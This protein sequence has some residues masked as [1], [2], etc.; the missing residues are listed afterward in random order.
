MQLLLPALLSRA[1][2]S[3]DGKARVIHTA[4]LGSTFAK[5]LDYDTFND[6]L[7]F[8]AAQTGIHKVVQSKQTRR[9]VCS[10]IHNIF[11]DEMISSGR[12]L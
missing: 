4:S 1:Q 7:N 3:A 6:S 8:E 2:S 9:C 5:G 11:A 12:E 10:F